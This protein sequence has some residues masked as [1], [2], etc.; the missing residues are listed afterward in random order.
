MLS[1]NIFGI[2][3]IRSSILALTV[4]ALTAQW[5]VKMLLVHP[6]APFLQNRRLTIAADCAVLSNENLGGRFRKGETVIIG[7][8]LLEDPDRMMSKLLLV[9]K[10][11]AAQDVEV[12][13]ME[14]PCCHAIHMMMSKARAESLKTG[15][16]AKH[17][18]V[19][20]SSGEVEPYK[21]GVIDES[22]ISAE[23]KAHGHAH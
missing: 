11:T 2:S 14:V 3:S 10:E 18:I 20:V 21:L 9:M 17:Y 16:N 7:C 6:E 5:P 19:R 13:T 8:P 4:V 15:I 23:R 1:P 22:M 12:Y